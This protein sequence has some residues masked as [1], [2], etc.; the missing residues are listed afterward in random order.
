[1]TINMPAGAIPLC[2][3]WP[4]ILDPES[5]R[6]FFK[7]SAR[8]EASEHKQFRDPG[9]QET[10]AR[11]FRT[12]LRSQGW[13]IWVIADPKK[14]EKMEMIPVQW[15]DW[16]SFERRDGNVLIFDC[17]KKKVV[18][19]H[20]HIQSPL[21][22]LAEGMQRKKM[23]LPSQGVTESELQQGIHEK[24]PRWMNRMMEHFRIQSGDL[25]DKDK[26]NAFVDQIFPFSTSPERY[27]LVKL[28]NK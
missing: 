20:V 17:Q 26:L 14:P 24:L 9:K 19:F 6:T 22:Y 2:E 7:R 11:L 27:N 16:M 15:L 13:K 3:A 21:L 4:L 18:Y 23:K 10:P 12:I 25:S 8:S 5:V 1:M 28:L